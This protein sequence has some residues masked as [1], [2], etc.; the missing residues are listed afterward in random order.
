MVDHPYGGPVSKGLALLAIDAADQAALS[1][2]AATVAISHN[3]QIALLLRP[4][5]QTHGRAAQLEM[6]VGKLCDRINWLSTEATQVLTEVRR[7]IAMDPMPAPKST[8]QARKKR[9]Q[10]A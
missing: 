10:H 1:I 5:E 2:E 6:D 4:R 3:M 9:A 8:S 7:I